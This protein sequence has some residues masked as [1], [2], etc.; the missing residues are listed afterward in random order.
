MGSEFD[1][2]SIFEEANQVLGFDLKKIMLEGP[3]EKLDS[4]GGL[5]MVV[6][7]RLF[8]EELK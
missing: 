7:S 5:A 2:P 4:I 3:E 6:S 1:F 8:M